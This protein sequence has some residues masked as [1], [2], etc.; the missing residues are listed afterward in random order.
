MSST[1]NDDLKTVLPNWLLNDREV[2]WLWNFLATEE[3]ADIDDSELNGMLMR[4]QIADVLKDSH[5]LRLRTETQKS[6]RLLPKQAFNWIK[7]DERQ[8]RWLTD[9]AMR[10]AGFLNFPGPS[11]MTGS[12]R[13]IFV[14]DAWDAE[15][16]TKDRAL[17]DLERNWN[18]HLQSDRVFMWFKQENELQ[19]CLMAWD[20]LENNKPRLT[21][22]MK[23]LANHDELLVLFDHSNA[24]ADEKKLYVELIKRRWNLNRPGFSRHSQ[25]SLRN[26]FQTLPVTADC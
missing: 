13:F 22:G 15:I 4:N 20:W 7:K 11:G 16:S 17:R 10:K 6:L 19:K 8:I 14:I 25:G 21:R 3:E 24:T 12:A 18:E 5:S 1:K 23:P 26:A 9:A 2:A